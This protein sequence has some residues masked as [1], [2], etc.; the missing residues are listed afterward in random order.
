M[1][2]WL[3][4]SFYGNV[5]FVSK[6]IYWLLCLKIYET[7]GIIPTTN[8]HATSCSLQFT[9]VVQ[10]NGNKHCLLRPKKSSKWRPQRIVISGLLFKSRLTLGGMGWQTRRR[11]G[12]ETTK[13][14]ELESCVITVGIQKTVKITFPYSWWFVFFFFLSDIAPRSPVR[15]PQIFLARLQHQL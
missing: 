10:R 6:H 14:G 5:I 8:C 2:C 13:A 12:M 4:A 11:A 7:D 1:S 9:L 15:I 3:C